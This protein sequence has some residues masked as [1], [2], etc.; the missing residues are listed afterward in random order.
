[1][2]ILRESAAW[3]VC[4]GAIPGEVES[5]AEEFLNIFP[6]RLAYR[7]SPYP[8]CEFPRPA[9]VPLVLVRGAAVKIKNAAERFQPLLSDASS[10]LTTSPGRVLIRR[11][12]GASFRTGGSRRE[13]DATPM[14]Y[15]IPNNTA[16]TA[17]AI[18]GTIRQPYTQN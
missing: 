5:V 13:N 7:S 1:M 6:G 2:S 9:D 3:S 16:Y 14:L 18:T 12:G 8:H 15:S 10:K 11:H 4:H 17:S